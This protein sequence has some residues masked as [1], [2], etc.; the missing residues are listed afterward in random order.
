MLSFVRILR[1][2][3]LSIIDLLLFTIWLTVCYFGQVVSYS[4]FCV[5]EDYSDLCNNAV[6]LA[7]EWRG[8]TV[9]KVTFL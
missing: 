2:I 1:P 8:T 4:G 3:N 6:E 5:E 7:E 9:D